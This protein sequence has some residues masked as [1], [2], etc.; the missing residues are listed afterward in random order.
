[1][2]IIKITSF[3]FSFCLLANSAQGLDQSTPSMATIGPSTMTSFRALV[4]NAEKNCPG[5]RCTDSSVKAKILSRSQAN[6]L[7]P[8]LLQK[9]THTCEQIAETEWPETILEGPYVA[10]F[11]VQISQLEVLTYSNSTLGYRVT[12]VDKAWNTENCEYNPEQPNSISAC[13]PGLFIESAFISAK[14]GESFRDPNAIVEFFARG[15]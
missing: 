10:S 12:Y 13:E 2:N 15:K 3:I 14:N 9:M 11:Q 4:L 6:Q 5:L 1:M 8:E 7:D